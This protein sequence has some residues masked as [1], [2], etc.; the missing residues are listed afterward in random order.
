[1]SVSTMDLEF[2]VVNNFLA[3]TKSHKKQKSRPFSF[4][5][6]KQIFSLKYHPFLADRIQ[7]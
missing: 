2:P 1:M 3:S 4:S 7:F 5:H 6:T